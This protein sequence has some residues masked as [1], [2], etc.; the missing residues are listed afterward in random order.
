MRR[1]ASL[2]DRIAVL[3]KTIHI[4]PVRLIFEDGSRQELRGR[5][6]FM[7][8]LLRAAQRDEDQLS[9]EQREQLQL[10][11]NAVG[12]EESGGARLVEAVQV[13][14]AAKDL[15]AEAKASECEKASELLQ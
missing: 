1:M 4:S 9:D 7:L 3:E 6:N 11:R 10:I 12:S 13:M 14:L 2:K 15:V 5:R 8:G